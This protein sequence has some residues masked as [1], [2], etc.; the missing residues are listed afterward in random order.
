MRFDAPRA[1]AVG[2]DSEAILAT[3]GPTEHTGITR[4]AIAN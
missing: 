1:R 4:L 3:L 2:T